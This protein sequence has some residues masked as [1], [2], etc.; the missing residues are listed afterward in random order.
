V[1]GVVFLVAILAGGPADEAAGEETELAGPKGRWF[2]ITN[3]Y[4]TVP[5]MLAL[6][7]AYLLG[8]TR[9]LETGDT[10]QRLVQIGGGACLVGYFYALAGVTVAH[11][12]THWVHDGI[13][14]RS[15]RLL[16]AF[17]FNTTFTIYHVHGHHRTVAQFNDAATARR[18]E[19]VYSFLLRTVVD[20]FRE[21]MRYEAN[22]LRRSG[23]SFWRNRAL[24]GYF[25][26]LG[27]L[28]LAWAIAGASG[29]IAFL[30]PAVLGRTLH[31]LMN[32]VQHYGLVRVEGAPIE[33]RHTWD[34]YHLLSN[35][36][37]YNLPRHSHHHM[38]AATPFWGLSISKGAPMLPHGYQTM[39]V[40]ALIGP[41]WRR[42]MRPLLA[43]WDETLASEA[44]RQLIEERGWTNA[45]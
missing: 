34:C 3:L 41:L 37:Q 9:A 11:E 15:A 43:Q 44:E 23:R 45:A 31:E 20:Q 39:A 29:V 4:A 13:A 10:M 28:A 27:L 24:N 12:L 18:G 42:T 2:Y 33:S 19:P 17:T 21:A 1:I 6:T 26:S 22:R 40:L 5:L 16:L 32:Y 35:A 8:V 7:I 30:A 25:Y 36:L 38:F 14:Q